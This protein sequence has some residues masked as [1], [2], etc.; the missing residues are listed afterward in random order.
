[1]RP[2]FPPS[3][4]GFRR[5]MPARNKKPRKWTFRPYITGVSCTYEMVEAEGLEP[6]APPNKTKGGRW[7]CTRE[8]THNPLPPELLDAM[9]TWGRLPE[10]LRTAVL[11]ILRMGTMPVSSGEGGQPVRRNS[12][13]TGGADGLPIG[14]KDHPLFRQVQTGGLANNPGKS[15][16]AL[17]EWHGS[18]SLYQSRMC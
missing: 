7:V 18:C 1:M 16:W 4:M 17:Q 13:S 9:R 10:S 15:D 11:A 6:T 14:K 5:G 2:C 8:R 12:T 3:F